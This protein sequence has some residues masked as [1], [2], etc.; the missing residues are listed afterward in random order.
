MRLNVWGTTFVQTPFAAM[1]TKWVK[2]ESYDHIKMHCFRPKNNYEIIYIH[3]NKN[4]I[5]GI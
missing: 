4:D 5:L 3:Q 2:N 1:S